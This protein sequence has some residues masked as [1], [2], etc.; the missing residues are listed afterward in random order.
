MVSLVVLE[1]PHLE[2]TSSVF[3]AR[4]VSMQQVAG[5]EPWLRVSVGIV[6]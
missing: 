6:K 4:E 1:C 3:S 2:K 5:E